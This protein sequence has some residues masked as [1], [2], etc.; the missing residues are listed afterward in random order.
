MA[1]L[2]TIRRLRD[3]W[4]R[5][6]RRRMPNPAL[7]RRVFEVLEDRT[8]LSWVA[9]IGGAGSDT[10]TDASTDAAGNVYVAG[11]FSGVVDF[12]PGAGTFNLDSATG[13]AFVAKYAPTGDLL[14]A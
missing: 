8:L 10:R 1:A 7:R 12:D 9:Q 6:P 2:A 14:W 3:R 5:T 11:N 13:N 4:T